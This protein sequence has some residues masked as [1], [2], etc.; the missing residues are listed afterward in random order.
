MD[1]VDQALL[2]RAVERY[3][4]SVVIKDEVAAEVA[5]LDLVELG[6]QVV[7]RQSALLDQT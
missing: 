2:A 6:L 5:L 1:W 7:S 4:G 3:A